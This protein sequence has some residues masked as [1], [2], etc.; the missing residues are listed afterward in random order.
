MTFLSYGLSPA[1]IG[2]MW[3]TAPPCMPTLLPG[4]FRTVDRCYRPN[5]ERC[6]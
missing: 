2:L 4:R 3:Q 5:C 6:A 1:E